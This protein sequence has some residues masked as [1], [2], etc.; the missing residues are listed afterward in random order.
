MKNDVIELLTIEHTQDA[1]GFDVEKVF[2][3]GCFGDVQSAKRSE[4]YEASKAGYNVQIVCAVNA[5]DYDSAKIEHGSRPTKVK[6]ED[7][8]YRIL[9]VY[10]NKAKHS[11]EL[12]LIEGD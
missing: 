2:S 11:V 1:D 12:T 3:F 8:V 7:E 10:R 4:F 6:Y 9:R 5:D